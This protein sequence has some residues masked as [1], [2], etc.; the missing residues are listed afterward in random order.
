MMLFRRMS[1]SSKCRRARHAAARAGAPTLGRCGAGTVKVKRRRDHH[2]VCSPRI[3]LVPRYVGAGVPDAP[4][5]FPELR[6]NGTYSP[7][8]QRGTSI[9]V[10]SI[11]AAHVGATLGRS[12]T[13]SQ[14]SCSRVRALSSHAGTTLDR[15]IAVLAGPSFRVANRW[16]RIAQCGQ[17][18]LR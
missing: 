17:R 4:R 8:T 9:V 12:P 10:G 1:S 11:R 16:S 6:L 14:S 3:G 7:S 5:R 18:P 15:A 13:P 2:H